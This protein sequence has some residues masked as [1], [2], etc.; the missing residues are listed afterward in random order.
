[1]PDFEAKLPARA[2]G[3]HIADGSVLPARRTDGHSA[4]LART[5]PAAMALAD[6]PKASNFSWVMRVSSLRSALDRVRPDSA[7]RAVRWATTSGAAT[8]ISHICIHGC[9]QP[10]PVLPL[11]RRVFVYLMV[12]AAASDGLY[13]WGI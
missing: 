7:I 2:V 1:M 3:I 13:G 10:R 11:R 8:A 6:S 9:H 5:I 12:D 4:R